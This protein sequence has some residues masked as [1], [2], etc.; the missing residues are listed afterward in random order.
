MSVAR[1]IIRNYGVSPR[2]HLALQPID[3]P[4]IARP[5]RGLRWVQPASKALW[6]AHDEAKVDQESLRRAIKEMR[7]AGAALEQKLSS[8]FVSWKAAIKRATDLRDSGVRGL[9]LADAEES[10]Q[11]LQRRVA[12]QLD[13]LQKRTMNPANIAVVTSASRFV[14]S[15][16]KYQDLCSHS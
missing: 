7:G 3:P 11:S 4:R 13:T 1:E 5:S 14:R 10:A 9:Q 8:T 12:N 6:S 2:E 16:R 15:F